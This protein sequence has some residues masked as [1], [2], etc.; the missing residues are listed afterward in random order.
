MAALGDPAS[1]LLLALPLSILNVLL[2]ARY[3]Q[4]A[5]VIY[6]SRTNRFA[7]KPGR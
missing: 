2:F 4:Q 6:S 5:E 7:Q 1:V 3:L